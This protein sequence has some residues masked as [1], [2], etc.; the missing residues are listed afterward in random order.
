MFILNNNQI[1]ICDLFEIGVTRCINFK[2]SFSWRIQGNRHDMKSSTGTVR[3]KK[4][5]LPDPFKFESIKILKHG[6]WI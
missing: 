3:G 5:R 2:G 1:F 6:R 4:T